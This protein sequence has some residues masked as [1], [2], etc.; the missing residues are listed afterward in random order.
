MSAPGSSRSI[1]P[2][3]WN[4]CVRL[5]TNIFRK[6][7]AWYKDYVTRKEE[8][9][10]NLRS[11]YS[12][13]KSQRGEFPGS[14]SINSWRP[15]QRTIESV[16]KYPPGW[17]QLAAFLHSED[18]FAIFRRFGMVHCRVLVQLQAEIQQLERK[19]SDLDRSDAAANSPNSWRLQM[20]DFEDSSDSSQRDLLKQLQEKILVYGESIESECYL[21]GKDSKR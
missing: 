3:I 15:A 21:K 4:Y 20:V 2:T 7:S 17:P 9:R 12:N 11:F 18:N 6:L 5:V 8:E 1:F 16:E 19:L 10:E 14:F 13:I